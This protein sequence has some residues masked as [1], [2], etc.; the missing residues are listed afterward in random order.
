MRFQGKDPMDWSCQVYRVSD[1]GNILEL[2]AL[3]DNFSVAQAAFEAAV[4]TRTYSRIELRERARVVR[5]V[6]TGWCN[7]E[8]KLCEI[9]SD[10]LERGGAGAS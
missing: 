4:H 7:H 6:R 9:L 1:D 2:L 8:T 3:T 5:V 10:S